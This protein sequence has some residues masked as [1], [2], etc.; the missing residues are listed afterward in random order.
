VSPDNVQEIGVSPG[1]RSGS[2]IVAGEAEHV[3]RTRRKT[4]SRT[5]SVFFLPYRAFAAIPPLAKALDTLDL[6]TLTMVLFKPWQGH[7]LRQRRSLSKALSVSWDSHEFRLT[8]VIPPG[9]GGALPWSQP[10]KQYGRS[11]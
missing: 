6:T 7:S 9:S 11:M 2:P 10:Q 8:S 3:E 5:R 4:W 1:G